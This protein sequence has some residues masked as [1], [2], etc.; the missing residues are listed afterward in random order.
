MKKLSAYLASG[1]EMEEKE[2]ADLLGQIE[3]QIPDRE[4]FR[5]YYSLLRGYRHLTAESAKRQ[6]IKIST[7]CLELEEW[8]EKDEEGRK[9][10]RDFKRAGS[11]V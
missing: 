10:E 2:L 5:Y 11:G 9:T 6:I 8:K 3:E 1:E 7:H 4:D